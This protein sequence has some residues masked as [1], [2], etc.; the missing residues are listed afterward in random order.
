MTRPGIEPL[1]PGSLANTLRIRPIHSLIVKKITFPAIPFC[2]TVLFQ[3]IQ[4]SISI[5]FVYTQL[6]VKTGLFQ[7]I[8]FNI[9]TQFSSICGPGSNGYEGVL[10]I[11]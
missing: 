9:S 8:Q 3:P 1:S 11:P 6:N 10:R 2:Q 5:G 7:T 4:F